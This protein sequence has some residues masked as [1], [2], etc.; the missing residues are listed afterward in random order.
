[1]FSFCFS[2]DTLLLTI[3]GLVPIVVKLSQEPLLTLSSR[4]AHTLVGENTN[5]TQLILT[6]RNHNGNYV[7]GHIIISSEFCARLH[8]LYIVGLPGSH[9]YVQHYY[10]FPSQNHI[11][12]N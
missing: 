12:L 8:L 5:V 11:H 7:A 9:K 1:M 2:L 3:Y 4:Y 6:V 10:K